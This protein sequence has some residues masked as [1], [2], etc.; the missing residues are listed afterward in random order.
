MR[1][2]VLT[3]SMNSPRLRTANVPVK[4]AVT[5]PDLV[6]VKRSCAFHMVLLYASGGVRL[7]F[8]NLEKL[9]NIFSELVVSDIEY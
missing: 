2:P 6:V 8:S 3:S 5:C 4:A 7:G 1:P 9:E